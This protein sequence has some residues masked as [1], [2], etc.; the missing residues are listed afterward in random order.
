MKFILCFSFWKKIIWNLI[1]IYNKTWLTY[2]IVIITSINVSCNWFLP[3]KYGLM[4]K[5]FLLNENFQVLMKSVW[6]KSNK[7]YD[8]IIYN[9][10]FLVLII[11]TIEILTKI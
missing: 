6:N 7:L 10:A 4:F 2:K 5:M 8:L 11:T 3:F 9:D 1:Y